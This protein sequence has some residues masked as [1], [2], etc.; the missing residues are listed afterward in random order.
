[1]KD[2][3]LLWLISSHRKAVLNRPRALATIEAVV[4][5]LPSSLLI[6][7][8]LLPLSRAERGRKGALVDHLH[9][10]THRRWRILH[11]GGPGRRRKLGGSKKKLLEDRAITVPSET[12]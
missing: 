10:E 2:K 4:G 5:R 9:Q 8:S 6:F 3:F 12:N 7:Q 1:M 11:Y